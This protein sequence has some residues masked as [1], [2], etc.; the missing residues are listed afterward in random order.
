M[1]EGERDRGSGSRRAGER[2]RGIEGGRKGGREGLKRGGKG[3]ETEGEELIIGSTCRP[4]Q[5]EEE[6]EMKYSR[7]RQAVKGGTPT[8]S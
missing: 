6:S 7:Q 8:A 2:D 1:S 3:R 4:W 5:K